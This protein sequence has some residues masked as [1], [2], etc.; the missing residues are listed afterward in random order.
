MLKNLRNS[1]DRAVVCE[2][3]SNAWSSAVIYVR[4]LIRYIA[5]ATFVIVIGHIFNWK[6]NLIETYEYELEPV[7]TYLINRNLFAEDLLG[8]R[9]RYFR[10]VYIC[11]Y[12]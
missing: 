1:N 5:N 10:C 2:A 7:T 3:A 11:D 6:L 9:C 4:V 8:Y 12:A